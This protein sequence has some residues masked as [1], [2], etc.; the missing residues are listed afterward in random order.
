MC[1]GDYLADLSAE[2]FSAADARMYAD[3]GIRP[4]YDEDD[5]PED[6]AE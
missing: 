2:G 1:Y 4:E 5:E 3:N 6:E